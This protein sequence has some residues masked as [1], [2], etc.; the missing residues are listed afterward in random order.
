VEIMVV[1]TIIS[2]LA[3]LALPALAKVKQKSIATAVANDLR[4]FAAAF[5][6]YATENGRWPAETDAGVFPPEMASRIKEA[7]WTTATRIG[8]NYN[9]DADQ[10]HQGTRYKAAIAITGSSAAALIEDVDLWE[11]VDRA[12][13]DG[14]LT[15]GSFR[16]GA[17]N[18]PVFIIAQ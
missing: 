10:M 16:I 6:A 15:T 17:D 8:G 11:A 18:E 4:V 1:V 9:W 5:D 12:I 14:V 7:S 3:A 2:L 13:D